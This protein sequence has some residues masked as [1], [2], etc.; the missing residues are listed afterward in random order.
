MVNADTAVFLTLV[1]A[2]SKIYQ[3][4]W[5]SPKYRIQFL[6]TESGN[7]LNFQGTKRWLDTNFE[8]TEWANVSGDISTES[9]RTHL[10]I[11]LL[12]NLQQIEFVLCLDSI[13]QTELDGGLFMH[14]SKPPK[15]GTHISRFFKQLKQTSERYANITVEGVHKKINLADVQLAW[16]HERFS[17]KRIPAFT[18]SALKSHKDTRRTTIFERLPEVS[19]AVAQRNAKILAETLAGY[20]YGAAQANEAETTE[21]FSGPTVRREPPSI[22]D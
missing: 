15:E 8:E 22:F 9:R 18:L 2:F 1:D 21:I 7:L 12:P 10:I 4:A 11:S 14:V 5:T 3:S 13:G 17:M 6:L 19:L 16:E 20:I